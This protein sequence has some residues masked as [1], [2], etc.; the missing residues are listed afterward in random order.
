[1]DNLTAIPLAVSII[2]L[3]WV[4]I[5][6]FLYVRAVHH[7]RK[8]TAGV[9]RGSLQ[10]ILEKHFSHIDELEQAVGMIRKEV[11]DIEEG[12]LKHLQR[13]GLIRFNPFGETGGNQSFA[14]ALLDDQGNGIVIS[15][16]HSR[17]STRIYGKPVLGWSESG[18]E[19]S[20]EEKQAIEKA[21]TGD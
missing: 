20:A 17:E 9:G 19:F 10:Q 4:I 12:D 6:T 5:L 18:F 7:Y 14:L 1:M 21:K 8:L 13:V 15:S 11:A 2:L 3:V 16:L